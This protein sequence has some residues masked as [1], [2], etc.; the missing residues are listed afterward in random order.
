MNTNRQRIASVIATWDEKPHPRA[1][2][3]RYA[4][5]LEALLQNEGKIATTGQFKYKTFKYP[6]MIFP[7][8][9]EV[10]ETYTEMIYRIA[11]DYLTETA[12]N[13]KE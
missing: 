3:N 7:G 5:Y 6:R 9:Y 1:M 10:K 11:Q 4:G 13:T 12:E 2:E 8:T